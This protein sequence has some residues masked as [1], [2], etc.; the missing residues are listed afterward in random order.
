MPKQ[1]PVQSGHYYQFLRH[2][3]AFLHHNYLSFFLIYLIITHYYVIITS[4][5]H[6]FR[7]LLRHYYTLLHYYYIIIT[8]Y[9]NII[10]SLLRRITSLFRII[11]VI[12]SPFLRIITRSSIRNNEFIITYYRPGQLGDEWLNAIE[13]YGLVGDHR[14]RHGRSRVV[15]ASRAGSRPNGRSLRSQSITANH[16]GSGR[17]H[18]S[19]GRTRQT[20]QDARPRQECR[21]DAAPIGCIERA[22]QRVLRCR[23]QGAATAANARELHRLSPPP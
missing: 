2:Y 19:H 21:R 8:Y 18:D 1:L 15:T 5:L 12:M 22:L 10:T 7:S 11:T 23:P 14:S 20:P 6:I 16:G 17:T 3:Y 4:L 13:S 9:N